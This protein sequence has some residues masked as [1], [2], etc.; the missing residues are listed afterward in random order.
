[1]L[2][3][4][5]HAGL[6]H[7]TEGT[8]HDEDCRRTTVFRFLTCEQQISVNVQAVSNG[9]GVG[10]LDP[11]EDIKRSVDDAVNPAPTSPDGNFLDSE[12]TDP[13]PITGDTD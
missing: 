9:T 12:P 1:M 3:S 7:P 2:A 5:S 11:M 8:S 13:P 4:Q 6:G 10:E